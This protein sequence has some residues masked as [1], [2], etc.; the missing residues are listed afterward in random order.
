MTQ[1]VRRCTSASNQRLH[2]C[3]LIYQFGDS[4]YRVQ[5]TSLNSA[6]VF[7]GVLACGWI[8]GMWGL[9]LGVPILV[10]IKTVCDRIEALTPLSELLGE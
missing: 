4:K 3:D 8:L 2:Y 9:F 7:V 10:A 5:M 1:N 6:A